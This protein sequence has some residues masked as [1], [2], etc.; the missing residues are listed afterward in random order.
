VKRGER[1][2]GEIDGN[3]IVSQ[4]PPGRTGNLGPVFERKMH[5]QLYFQGLVNTFS[6]SFL[7]KFPALNPPF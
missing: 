4:R 6:N 5:L 7:S 2:R 3:D 1:N